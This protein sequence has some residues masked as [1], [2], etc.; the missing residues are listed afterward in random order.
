M[1]LRIEEDDGL[2]LLR[3]SA[4]PSTRFSVFTAIFEAETA[5]LYPL[6]SFVTQTLNRSLQWTVQVNADIIFLELKKET[7]MLRRGKELRESRLLARPAAG[8]RLT[9]FL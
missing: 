5:F 1:R 3:R 2:W 8:V 9:Q 7:F 4:S 6:F